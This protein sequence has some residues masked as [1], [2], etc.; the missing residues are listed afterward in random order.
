M[1]ASLLASVCAATLFATPTLAQDVPASTSDVDAEAP[2]GDIIVTATR[3]EERLQD[4]PLSI[5]A[6]AQE[7]LTEKGIVGHEGLAG[8]TP[9]IVLNKQTAN[10]KASPR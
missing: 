5:T 8:E 2:G 9:G 3:R 7:Q 1:R 4:V 10:T 6:F